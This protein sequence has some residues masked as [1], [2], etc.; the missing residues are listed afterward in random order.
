MLISNHH[1][2]TVRLAPLLLL[3]PLLADAAEAGLQAV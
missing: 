2:T 1:G 3:L